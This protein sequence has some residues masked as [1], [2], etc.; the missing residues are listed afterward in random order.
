MTDLIRGQRQSASTDNDYPIVC[1]HHIIAPP[2]SSGDHWHATSADTMLER[3][4]DDPLFG[5]RAGSVL[6]GSCAL[7]CD[8]VLEKAPDEPLEV[9][10]ARAVAAAEAR[11]LSKATD[12]EKGK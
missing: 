12:G 3:A 4:P 10:E 9:F 11:K 8:T 7:V 5:A 2:P 1:I 6:V